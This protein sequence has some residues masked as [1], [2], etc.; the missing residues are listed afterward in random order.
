MIDCD[1]A[2]KFM[3]T[4]REMK[5]RTIF[6]NPIVVVLVGLRHINFSSCWC[7]IFSGEVCF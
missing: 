1:D 2:Y 4:E 6:V 5:R 7:S 3:G